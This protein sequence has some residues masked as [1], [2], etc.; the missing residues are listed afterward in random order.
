MDWLEL[1]P[2]TE[3]TNLDAIA[4]TLTRA[5][6]PQIL[7]RDKTRREGWELLPGNKA[8]KLYGEACRALKEDAK[9]RV[10][11]VVGC[12]DAAPPPAAP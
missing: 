1:P 5:G 12:K 2:A 3:S 6:G 7:E 10:Q 9:A 11:V 8:F 4:V